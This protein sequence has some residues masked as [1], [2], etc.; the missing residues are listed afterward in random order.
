MS[1]VVLVGAQ[2][3][4]EGKAKITDL[5]SEYADIIVR[6]QGGSNA[7]HT[8][9]VGDVTYKFH[10]IPSGILYGNK[11]C[12]V[13]P[14]TVINPEIMIEEIEDLKRKNIDVSNLK[15]SSSAHVTLPYHIDLDKANEESRGKN[16]IGTTNRGIGPTYV[17]KINRC[18]IRI[19]D[20]LNE[21]VLNEKL[22]CILP[23]KN[24]VLE[25]IYGLTPY[26]KSDILKL[27]KKHAEYLAPFIINTASF[28]TQA[29]K[30]KKHILFEGAQG[31][32]L[33]ID[34]GTYP[35]VTSSN[36]IAGGAC[37]S[38]GIGPTFIDEVIGIS[39]AYATRVG[40]GPFVSE[41][42]DEMGD[43]LQE[44]GQEFGT[45][46][47]RSRRCGWFDAVAA[48]YSVLVNGLTCLAL[49]KID[50]FNQFEE[51]KI[52]TAY[53]NNKTGEIY[54]DYPTNTY[55]H[56]DLEPVYEIMQGWNEDISGV[57]NYENLPANAKKYITRVEQLIG[58]KA[59]I[60]ST[61]A[62]REHTIVLRNPFSEEK[63]D[64][65]I[66]F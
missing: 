3:G 27:C 50:V 52:C 4:D 33:D 53:K 10:L 29:L 28:M 37:T 63:K 22:D 45:T 39:K 19:E 15:I 32:M 14:G 58:V 25:K 20:L 34:H 18:G 43:K 55:I 49:T 8:V 35:Y 42:N 16:K 21:E 1:N 2:W 12:I 30:D 56:K 66:N 57:N 48:R 6:Y 47:G 62:K 7:G 51:I 61:G 54:T 5:L 38:V 60:I 23:Q 59:G 46:T 65:L 36:P 17:D 26:K 13:G 24:E 11:T 40:E 64:L 9:I 31:T 44:I 41:L